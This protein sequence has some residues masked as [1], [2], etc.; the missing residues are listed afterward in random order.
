M[1]EHAK[2]FVWKGVETGK[3]KQLMSGGGPQGIELFVTNR[4]REQGNYWLQLMDPPM[5]PAGY[6]GCS[7]S[8]G[9]MDGLR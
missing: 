4:I 6:N 9:Y 8:S 1:S 2:S 5:T 3:T 7:Q